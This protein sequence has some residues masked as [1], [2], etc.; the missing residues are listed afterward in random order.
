VTLVLSLVI[1]KSAAV[2]DVPAPIRLS[3]P[4]ISNCPLPEI[5]PAKLLSAP[6][7]SMVPVPQTIVP[8]S[9]TFTA[10]VLVPSP[11]V[12]SRVAWAAL[13]NQAVEAP[14]EIPKSPPMSKVP[15]FS[16]SIVAS[17]PVSSPS[18]IW[19]VRFVVFSLLTDAAP[20]RM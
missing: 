18:V 16:L 3:P 15:P 4:P 7:N 19:L 1:V 17:M 20:P 8:L 6:V 14:S 9:V 2:I 10:I 11:P 5:A 12:F 13:T